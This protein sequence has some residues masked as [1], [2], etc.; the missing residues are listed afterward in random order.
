[1]RKVALAA[2]LAVVLLTNCTKKDVRE[3][4]LSSLPE[5]PSISPSASQLNLDGSSDYLILCKAQAIPVGL[6]KKISAIG[7]V[8]KS[9]DELGIVLASSFNPNFESELE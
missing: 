8:K 6:L 5:V 9:I 7:S 1:M 2:T 3:N 4:A